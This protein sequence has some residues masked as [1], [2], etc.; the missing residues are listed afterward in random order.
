MSG[1]AHLVSFPAGY[2]LRLTTKEPPFRHFT[3]DGVNYRVCM[4]SSRFKLFSR[5]RR[6]VCCNLLGTQMILDLHRGH[7]QPHFN[8]YGVRN[9]KLVLFTRDHILPKSKGGANNITN[10]QTMCERC[11]KKKKNREITVKQLRCE[12][13]IKTTS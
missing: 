13:G 3:V 12:L 6:C 9:G 8:L 2:I 11:N 5:K 1:I 7:A 4:R 10:Y